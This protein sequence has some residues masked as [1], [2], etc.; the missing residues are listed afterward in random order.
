MPMATKLARVVTYH[1]VLALIK[2]HDTLI[3]W[4]CKITLQTKFI[5]TSLPGGYDHQTLQDSRSP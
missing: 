3:T 2:S 1:E 4:S 5:K